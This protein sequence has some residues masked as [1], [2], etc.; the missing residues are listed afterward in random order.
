MALFYCL[1]GKPKQN[2]NQKSF[3]EKRVHTQNLLC[4]DGAPFEDF[5]LNT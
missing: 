3:V 1:F 2:L 5:S 4:Y